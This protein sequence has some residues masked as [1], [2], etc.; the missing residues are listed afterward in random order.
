MHG[1]IH[2]F[3][4][5]PQVD[6][7]QPSAEGRPIA[8]V[9]SEP[10]VGL[11]RNPHSHGNEGSPVDV[12]DV[13]GVIVASPSRRN[14]L[15]EILANF[16]AKGVDFIAIDGGDGTVRDVLTTGAGVF[17]ESWPA[18]IIMPSG[19]TNALAHDL[20]I[21]SGWTLAEALDAARRDKTVVRRP[22][23]VAQHDN[24]SAQVRGFVLGAGVYTQA[25]SLG[26]NA[27]DFGVFNAAGVGV[28]AAWS[29]LQALFGSPGNVWRRATRMR[30]RDATG[31][32]LPHAGG[33]PA[34]ERYALFVSTLETFPAGLRPFKG[35]EAPLRLALLDNSR[36]RVLLRLP[37]IFR[38][39]AGKGTQ[40]MGYQ[41]LGLE[42]FDFDIGD[43]FILDGEAFPPGSYRVTPGPRLRFIVP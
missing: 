4:R 22:L 11:I 33:S 16:A 21:R 15:P 14:E 34:D 3:D 27:H 29:L 7:P 28:T 25:I 9:R 31:A 5:L 1:A 40:R 8:A 30:L 39:N 37:L 26:Q 43:R 20:G 32:D 35:I 19:K 41:A 36:W 17:G 2:L 24:E 38:G 10:L 12:G 42:A 6:V 23:V 13:P 18:L